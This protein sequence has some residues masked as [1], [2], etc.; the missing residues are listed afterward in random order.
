[1]NDFDMDTVPQLKDWVTLPEVAQQVGMTRQAMDKRMR[2]GYFSTLSWLGQPGFRRIY[3]ISRT[4]A[5][6]F[7]SD[8]TEL[9]E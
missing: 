3:V 1:M 2:R 6:K 9:V 5:E 8:H 7:V 4:E